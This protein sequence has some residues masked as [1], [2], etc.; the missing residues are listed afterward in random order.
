VAVQHRLGPVTAGGDRGLATWWADGADHF[1]AFEQGGSTRELAQGGQ[2]PATYND[3]YEHEAIGPM[4]LL[5]TN[6]TWFWLGVPSAGW[7]QPGAR[8]C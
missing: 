2:L 3:I 8:E 7:S 4:G 1:V 5:L 6:G